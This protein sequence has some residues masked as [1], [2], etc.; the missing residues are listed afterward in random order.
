M[1][2]ILLFALAAAA[3][4]AGLYGLHQWGR[5]NGYE[6]VLRE[7]AAK[8]LAYRDTNGAFVWRKP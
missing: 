8:Y 1:R 2:R 6:R 4:S 5:H 3:A 7:A